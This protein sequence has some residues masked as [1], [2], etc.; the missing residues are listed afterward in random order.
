MIK[1]ICSYSPR[2]VHF[3]F[4]DHTTTFLSLACE[5]GPQNAPIV[6]FLLDHGAMP[7]DDF[8]SYAYHFGVELLPAIQH[9]QP[10]EI[11][12]KMIPKTSKLWMPTEVAIRR[13][14]VDVLELLLNEEGNRGE[15]HS[16]DGKYEQSLLS[17]AQAT[18]DKKVIAVG[19]RYIRNMERRA[20][21]S[22]SKSKSASRD[23]RSTR[24]STKGRRWWPFGSRTDP[25]PPQ[26][27]KADAEDSSSAPPWSGA[28]R[29]WWWPLSKIARETKSTGAYHEKKE[30]L[31]SAPDEED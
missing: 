20:T 1:L 3:G 26:A 19:E 27:C 17:R 9:D 5:G 8:G 15:K 16:F 14:R 29:W 6:D 25:R 21:K 18:E 23:F 28:R 7:D 31:D 22:K 4:D 13:K 30:P 12:K 11:I 10:T 2:I 24:G